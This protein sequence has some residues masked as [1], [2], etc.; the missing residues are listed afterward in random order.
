MLFIVSFG[1][2]VVD[3]HFVLFTLHRLKVNFINN[4]L[5]AFI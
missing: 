2:F 4:S 3:R 5:S 1:S